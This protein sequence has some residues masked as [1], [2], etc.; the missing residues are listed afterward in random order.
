VP[1]VNFIDQTVVALVLYEM[2]LEE[3]PAYQSLS[4]ALEQAGGTGYL[5]IHDN[6]RESRGLPS[7]SPW[8][9]EYRHDP[10]NPGVSKAYNQAHKWAEQHQKI[11]LLLAD[12]DTSFPLD[13]FQHYLAAIHSFPDCLLFTPLL[14]DRKGILSPFRRSTASG[15]RLNHVEPGLHP[16]SELQAVNSG[17]MVS[18]ALF[19]A[20]GGYDE[21]LP[22]DFSDFSFFR[23]VAGLTSRMAVLN[24]TCQH[25]HSS[26]P[27]ASLHSATT[28]FKSYL[29]G[30]GIM[31][32]KGDTFPFRMSALLHALRLTIRHRSLIFIKTLRSGGQ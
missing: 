26:A 30:S 17:L 28:R 27:G 18:S 5:F 3:S 29:H 23:R 10:S 16:L 20:S 6:S 11:W 2:K 15:R 8:Q 21:R 1:P 32:E 9:I 25:Q 14:K 24:A 13:I 19:R 7:Q 22:L 12:Q 31:A 4:R